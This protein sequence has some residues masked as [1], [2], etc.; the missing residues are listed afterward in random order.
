MTGPAGRRFG[1]V[2]VLAWGAAVGLG[3]LVGLRLLRRDHHRYQ[4]LAEGVRDA[5]VSVAPFVLA[6][7]VARRRPGLVAL[8]AGLTVES[9]RRRA[10]PGVRRPITSGAE[11]SPVLCRVVTVNLLRSNPRVAELARQLIDDTADILLIQELSHEHLA[12]LRSNGLLRA[13]PEHVLDPTHD[14]HG[15]AVLSR[16][17]LSRGHVLDVHGF[18]MAAADVDAPGGPMHV[19]SVHVVNPAH[20]RMITTWRDQLSWLAGYVHRRDRPAVLAG[21]FNATRDHRAMQTL[22]GAG[23]TDAHDQAGSG[24]GSTWPRRHWQTG[25]GRF[26]PVMRLDHVLVTAE[27]A[28][29]SVRTADCAGG[30]HRRVVAEII[31]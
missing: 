23:L 15:S 24:L 8:A 12:D 2:D 21:D 1:A 31:R 25:R 16:W 28:V 14:F 6:V 4:I 27:L 18:G 17:P 29:R 19:V 7:G 10:R 13:Y 30:D 20:G 3:G 11:A 22:L 9:G 5:A 26:V